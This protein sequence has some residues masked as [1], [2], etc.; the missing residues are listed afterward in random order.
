M[1]L[2]LL[3]LTTYFEPLLYLL[4]PPTARRHAKRNDESALVQC[5][6]YMHV[7]VRCRRVLL[8]SV[9]PRDF[10]IKQVP[11]PQIN[12]DEVLL[13]GEYMRFSFVA[14]D[15]TDVSSSQLLR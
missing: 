6:V 4:T 3:P 9:Q 13:K 10:V 15:L 1:F 14:D 2:P 8:T 5:G 11:I 12:D 7:N